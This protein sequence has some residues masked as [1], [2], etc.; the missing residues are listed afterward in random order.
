[1][2][3]RIKAMIDKNKGKEQFCK[4]CLNG[5][6]GFDGKNTEKYHK[7]VVKD[8]EQTFA[9]QINANFVSTRELSPN[10]YLVTYNPRSFKCDTCIQE[11]YFTLDNAKFWYLNFVYNFMYRCLDMNKM[12]FIEGDTDSAYWAIAGDPNK[13]YHQRFEAVIKDKEFYDQHVYEWLPDP[14]KDVYD[15]KKLLGLAIENEDENCIALAPKCYCLFG[16]KTIYK[17]KGV[18]KEGNKFDGDKY[19]QVLNGETVI[20]GVNVNFQLKNKLLSKI[21]IHKN[22]LTATNTKAVVL[23]NH[24]CPPFIQGINANLYK[25]S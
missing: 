25:I 8:R 1:M 2:N 4:T 17:T 6:Y 24:S 9:S 23:Q 10:D 22:A 16:H 7:L 18:C 5:S 11:S 21:T 3:E 15:E 13:D 20:R 12:H 14:T 19:K